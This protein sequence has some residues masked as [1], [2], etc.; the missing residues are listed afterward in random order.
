[1]GLEKIY[2][3]NSMLEYLASLYQY[4]NMQEALI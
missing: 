4:T 1:M 3:D 2:I